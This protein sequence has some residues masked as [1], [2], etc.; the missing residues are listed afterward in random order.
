MLSGGIDS[1]AC[2][3]FY[4]QQ[5]YDVECIFYDYGQPAVELEFNSALKIADYFKVPLFSYEINGLSIPQKGEIC[6]RNAL[7]SI[8]TLSLNKY[9]SYKII[10]GIHSGTTYPD[11]SQNFVKQMNKVID[12]YGNGKIVLEAPFISW[13]KADIVSY[14]K[15]AALPISLTYSCESGKNPPCGQCLS[16]LDRK[17]LLDE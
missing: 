14:C 4:I 16:C 1:M 13:S 3:N 5:K 9:S 2:L 12:C 10:I 7:L 11:C 15:N 17:E 6:G 8:Y